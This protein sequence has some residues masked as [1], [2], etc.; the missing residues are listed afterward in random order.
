MGSFLLA[1]RDCFTFDDIVI[2]LIDKFEK[3]KR[4]VTNDN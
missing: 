4:G 3:D 1:L 2:I